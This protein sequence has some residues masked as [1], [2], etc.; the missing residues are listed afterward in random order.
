MTGAPGAVTV[1]G[2]GAS[3]CHVG[4]CLQA[5]GVP[6]HYVG[7]PRVLGDLRKHGLRLTDLDGR[8]DRLPATT[9]QLHDRPPA[10]ASLVLL[11]VKS[12]ATA[13]GTFVHPLTGQEPAAATVA[14]VSSQS[15]AGDAAATTPARGAPSLHV[16]T[17][18]GS[19]DIGT[20]RVKV[21]AR[22]TGRAGRT[23][24]LYIVE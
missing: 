14:S 15:T 5:A 2:A 20:S 7:R 4:G 13:E 19:G 1:M 21:V 24:E 11:C 17:R 10:G 22:R 6:V 8:D 23:R 9:L 18:I 16:S 3:G 12:G